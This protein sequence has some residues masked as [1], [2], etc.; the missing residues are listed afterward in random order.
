MVGLHIFNEFHDNPLTLIVVCYH[1]SW[2][3]DPISDEKRCVVLC[4]FFVETPGPKCCYNNATNEC[5]KIQVG[6]TS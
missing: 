2:N 5:I 6:K 4:G 1:E 3:Y